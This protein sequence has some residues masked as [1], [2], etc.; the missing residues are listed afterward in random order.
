MIATPEMGD[1]NAHAEDFRRT[2]IATGGD[3]YRQQ[4]L[5]RR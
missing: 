4:P 1:S 3:D 2:P 5:S